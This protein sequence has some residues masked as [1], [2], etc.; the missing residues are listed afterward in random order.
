MGVVMPVKAVK[1]PALSL[2]STGNSAV[3]TVRP[4][5]GRW[6]SAGW[7]VL[8]R[9]ALGVARQVWWIP[10]Y[11]P[12][13][14]VLRYLVELDPRT[15]LAIVGGAY[16]L[17]SLLWGSREMRDP[18]RVF[19]RLEFGPPD[20]PDRF[21]IVGPGPAGRW[22]PTA[23]LLEVRIVH[24]VTGPVAGRPGPEGDGWK[25]E[26]RVR[27]PRSLYCAGV[28]DPRAVAAELAR[29]LEPA[30]VPVEF[31]TA[32]R[33]ARGLP[34]A[35]RPPAGARPGRAAPADAVPEDAVPLDAVP[36]DAPPAAVPPE[37]R[38]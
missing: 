31:V 36:V 24:L 15:N 25:V 33:A 9:A 8:S 14:L 37:Q 7:I 34:A 21:R 16:L 35:A 27:E 18:L 5:G 3:L 38:P 12:L 1:Q 32:R 22:R 11:I 10:A 28:G 19:H 26:V 20:A 4:G 17:C 30:G 23:D 29:A 13:I 2:R 6:L